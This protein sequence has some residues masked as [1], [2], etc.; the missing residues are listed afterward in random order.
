MRIQCDKRKMVSRTQH[1]V[2]SASATAFDKGN[3]RKG[4]IEFQ[5]SQSPIVKS[6]IDERDEYIVTLEIS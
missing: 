1:S 5:R 3:F 4:R 6:N 2:G